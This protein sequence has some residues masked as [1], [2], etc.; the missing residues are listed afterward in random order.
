[1]TFSRYSDYLVE[2]TILYLNTTIID[3]GKSVSATFVHVG[4]TIMILKVEAN[5]VDNRS[6]Y[7]CT[8]II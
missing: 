3:I 4:N 5:I 2:I 8:S 1:M 7:Q 6:D